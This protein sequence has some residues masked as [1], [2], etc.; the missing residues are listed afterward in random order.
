MKTRD[1]GLVKNENIFDV[2]VVGAG[3]AGAM[4]AYHA[5][6]GGCRVVMIERKEKVGVPVRCGEAVGSKGFTRSLAVEK[7]WILSTIKSIRMVS[8]A[9]YKVD[10][11]NRNRIGQNYVLNR[12]IM[13]DELVRKAVTAGVTYIPST[14]VMNISCSGRYHYTAA[15]TGDSYEASSVI[16]A[17]GVESKCA[18]NLGWDTTLELEDI[19][20]CAFCHVTH[21]L[22]DNET[23]EFHVGNS[24]A[25]GGFVWVF[26]RGGKK[27][28]VG[29]G[30]LGTQSEGGRAKD[31]IVSF[32]KA[33]FPGAEISDVHCGG[34]PVGKWLK[35]LVRGG[36]LVVGDAARQV[37]SLTGGGIAYAMFAGK[38]AG[39]TVAEAR[40]NTGFNYQQ[41]TNYQKKWAAYCGKQQIRSY[42]LKTTLLKENN[43]RFFDTIARSLLKENPEQ[44]SYM[45]VFMRTFYKHP[46]ILLKTFF[47]FR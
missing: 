45:R 21:D 16:I 33:K 2:M 47:L 29:L 46:L 17:D 6:V 34:A 32:V 12:E 25:P 28:N 8:P 23:I 31:L 26:P 7:H 30:I 10:L 39:E 24:I 44:L 27:A 41:F 13:D 9:G 43:D 14:T 40:N 15:T 3:P 4:A 37:N 42:A 35:P 11:V 22:I 38:T 19:E 1:S 5:A 20:S 36:A 18:R